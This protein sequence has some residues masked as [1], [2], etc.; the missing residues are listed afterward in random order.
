MYSAQYHLT[1][2]HA[3]LFHGRPDPEWSIGDGWWVLVE[4]VLTQIEMATTREERAEICIT[5]VV[6]ANGELVIRSSHPDGLADVDRILHEARIASRDLCVCC[7][8]YADAHRWSPLCRSCV[9]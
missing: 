5:H 8:G 6:E 9:H 4:F 1:A 3:G 7:G 2:R